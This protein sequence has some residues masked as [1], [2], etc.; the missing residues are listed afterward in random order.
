MTVLTVGVQPSTAPRCPAWCVR[1]AGD[2]AHLSATV[3]VPKSSFGP[4]DGPFPAA[5]AG[6]S[7][8]PDEATPS[9]FIDGADL[10]TLDE[11]RRLL[12]EFGAMVERAG[13]AR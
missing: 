11:A 4:G 13:G 8:L 5:T 3:A 9:L 12:A 2:G 10:L 7:Q 1:H 6:M